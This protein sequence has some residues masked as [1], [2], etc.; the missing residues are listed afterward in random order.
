MNDESRTVWSQK[1]IEVEKHNF[2]VNHFIRNTCMNKYTPSEEVKRICTGRRSPEGFLCSEIL[3]KRR[4]PREDLY[5]HFYLPE[6]DERT[7]HPSSFR[8][9][10]SFSCK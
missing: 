9:D 3:S 10:E 8:L 6:D 7:S 2:Q 4:I 1:Q 5:I